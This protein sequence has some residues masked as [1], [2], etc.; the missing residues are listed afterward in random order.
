MLAD[1]F[2]HLEHGA[3]VMT[4]HGAKLVVGHNGSLVGRVLQTVR[5]DVV[6]ELRHH[7]SGGQ[8]ISPDDRRVFGGGL[9][10]LCQSA[11]GAG[12]GGGDGG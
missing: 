7:F 2:L 3:A 12:L 4:E 11:S 10:G 1:Q 8:G 5:P 6:P 9:Y